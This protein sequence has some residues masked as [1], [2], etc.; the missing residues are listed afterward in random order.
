MAAVIMIKH[1]ST[2]H[3]AH[4]VDSDHRV[5]IKAE[6]LQEAPRCK[7]NVI[8]SCD[9]KQIYIG[10]PL[11]MQAYNVHCESHCQNGQR[12]REGKSVHGLSAAEQPGQL[13][14]EGQQACLPSLAEQLQ[15]GLLPVP[16]VLLHLTGT[17]AVATACRQ[18]FH[19][20]HSS[21]AAA[22]G[23]ESKH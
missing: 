23:N 7:V 15:L 10:F 3:D 14:C 21:C 20:H 17:L 4:D 18:Q 12:A 9:I 2:C 19:G 1:F 8:P 11:K 13:F 22:Q 6:T 5:M 16:L